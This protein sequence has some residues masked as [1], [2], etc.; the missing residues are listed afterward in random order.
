MTYEKLTQ[1]VLYCRAMQEADLDA[2]C[3]TSSPKGF[4]K[5]SFMIQ[6]GRYYMKI[7]GLVCNN[8]RHE[9]VYT[10]KALIPGKYGEI[11]IKDNLFQPCPKCH[12]GNIRKVDELDFMKYLAYDNDDVRDL[13]YDL[14]DYCPILPDEGVRFLM[15][16]DWML[17][18]S[19]MMKKL[20]AQMRTKHRLLFT[21]IPKFKWLDSKYRNDMTTFWVRILNRGLALLLQ[22]DLGENDDPWH[23]KELQKMLKDYFYFTKR[24][25]L[26]ERAELL[27]KKHPCVFDYFMIPKVPEPI[28]NRY[29]LARD[30]KVFEKESKEIQLDQKEI[31]KIAAWN[32]SNNWEKIA[33]A[34]KM[35]SRFGKPTLKMLE[36]FVFN[37]PKTDEPIVRYTTIRNWLQ[38]VDKVMKK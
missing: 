23:M 27:V 32:I 38:T 19:K 5:S 13:I 11:K 24:E 16:E 18:E 37:H 7:F 12:S 17:T 28:Y 22:P 31:A 6:M 29:L 3:V 21:N 2:L 25:D 30:A 33:G 26:I 4:G 34:V 36:S 14:P 9:W 1:F 20:F 10:G 35:Q 15:G 8:C